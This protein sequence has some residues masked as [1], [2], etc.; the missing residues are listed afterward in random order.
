MTPESLAVRNSN[1]QTSRR[2]FTT[3]KTATSSELSP[4]PGYLPIAP[5]KNDLRVSHSGSHV[6]V[7]GLIL[8]NRGRILNDLVKLEIWHLSPNS[9]KYNHRAVTFTDEM[10]NYQFITDLP[11]RE[12]GHNYKIYLRITS[13]KRNFFTHLSFNHAAAFISTMENNRLMNGS[14]AMSSLKASVLKDRYIIG[15][16][17]VLPTF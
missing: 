13:G 10:G 15:L 11:N 1:S 3:N 17:I 2:H 16:N 12:I 4:Y 6:Q 14:G 7:Q 8:G 9:K 5:V